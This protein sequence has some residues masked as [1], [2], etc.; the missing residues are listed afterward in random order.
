MKLYI[1]FQGFGL[2]HKEWNSKPHFL[3]KL[4][5]KGK[6]FV[7]RNKWIEQTQDYNLSYLQME[8]F[9]KN[10][11]EDV[12]DKFQNAKNYDWIPVGFSFGGLFA[13]AFSKIYKNY[14]KYCVLLDNPHYLTLTNNKN[15]IKGTTKMLGNTFRQL[16]QT[17][18][19]KLI[20]QN[21]G[22][23]LDWGVISFGLWIQNNIC[24]GTLPLP[25]KGFYNII[26]PDEYQ[27]EFNVSNNNELFN[28]VEKLSKKNP[29]KYKYYF[30]INA[31]HMVFQNK[32]FSEIILQEI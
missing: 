12:L 10:A 4:R 7:H 1:L 26:Y 28:E 32:N 18:F 27:K 29:L 25:V 16:S 6:V 24:G 30:H 31:T 2:S 22:Y 8:H 21:S 11:Y 13:I 17:Q 23:L 14:C 3:T 9:I 5:K 19:N 15:R 20:K